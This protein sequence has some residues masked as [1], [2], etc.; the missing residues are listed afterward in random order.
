MLSTYLN[1]KMI[2]ADGR[3]HPFFSPLVKTG[4]T[5][6]SKPNIQNVPR[7]EGLRNIY[8]PAP[9]CVLFAN[10]YSQVELCAL[11]QSCYQRFGKSRMRELIN[12]G[13]DLHKW[14]GQIIK[15]NDSRPE[16]EKS[17]DKEY[18]QLAKVPNFGL[19]GGLGV[20]KLV[21]FAHNNYGVEITLEE[22][23]KLKAL[24]LE[25]FP[26]MV[27]HLQPQI[28]HEFSNE[29]EQWYIGKTINGRISRRSAYNSAC[30]YEFQGLV[31]D[32]AN[33]QFRS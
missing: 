18:R 29:E 10:D 8:I 1:D 21:A 13:E 11:A 32:G 19:P 12:D 15:K 3:V 9:D 33:G 17:T 24:W 22:A 7:D 5:S 14:F 23:V 28:D 25:A 20:A 2:G 4:R 27:D 16:S 30:N 6:C 26:E 31:A